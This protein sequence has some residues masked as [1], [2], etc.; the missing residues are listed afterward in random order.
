MK[1]FKI[2]LFILILALFLNGAKTFEK[3]ETW[4][5]GDETFGPFSFGIIDEDGKIIAAFFYS[6]NRVITPNKIIKIAPRG[7][8]PGDLTDMMAL[9][10]HNNDIA[11]VE[12]ADKVKIFQ[13][14]G[15]TYKIK[16]IKWLKRGKYA[17][18]ISDG[19]YLDNK[20]FLAGFEMIDA[21]IDKKIQHISFL[22][23]YDKEGKPLKNLIKKQLDKANQF[24]LM[25]YYV[26]N[27]KDFVY[28][29]P[30]N[31]L[32]VHLI[33]LKELQV[34]KVVKLEIP[35]FYK[36]M[37]A[38]FYA[39]KMYNKPNESLRKDFETWKTS[40][41][42][43]NKVVTADDY[44]VL[45]MR[46]CSDKLKKFALLFYNANTFKLEKTIFINDL[47]INTRDSKYYFFANGDPGRD[48]EAEDVKIHICSFRGKAKKK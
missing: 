39:W 41:S 1:I 16:E 30:E 46:T 13:K 40:Y 2:L 6:G 4:H 22:K 36:K 42:R 5:P 12:R 7:Q 21:D 23:I 32:T 8:G 11:F 43:I 48:E 25:D 24:Y 17:H 26:V 14:E 34:E 44:L 10:H 33:S 38:D 19:I 20:W 27:Y 47:L 28:F 9:F 31:E 29:L 18:T 3:I 35:E 37:P 15:E 45:Q